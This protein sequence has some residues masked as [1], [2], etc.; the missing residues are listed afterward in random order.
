[1]TKEFQYFYNVPAHAIL[2]LNPFKPNG[3]TC[4]YQLDQYISVLRVVWCDFYFFYPTIDIMICKQTVD[5]LV[6]PWDRVST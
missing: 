1:M 2:L 4:P 3:L 5:T 6:R